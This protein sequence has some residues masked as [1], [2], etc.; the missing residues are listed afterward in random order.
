MLSPRS[1]LYLSNKRS[2]SPQ[3]KSLIEHTLAK[4]PYSSHE[5]CAVY[6]WMHVMP[7][8]RNPWTEL[9][10]KKPGFLV[11]TIL[12][13]VGVLS[14]LINATQKQSDKPRKR[15][16]K[17]THESANL[18]MANPSPSTS[19]CVDNKDTQPHNFVIPLL[20]RKQLI[21]TLRRCWF[22]TSQTNP[23]R[24]L[25]KIKN[26]MDSVFYIILTHEQI[27]GYMIPNG[28]MMFYMSR[29][30]L[31]NNQPDCPPVIGCKIDIMRNNAAMHTISSIDTTLEALFAANPN[32]GNFPVILEWLVYN[33]KAN[34][35]PSALLEHGMCGLASTNATLL[36]VNPPN[37]FTIHSSRPAK[38]KPSKTPL[39][40]M[41]KK[42]RIKIRE[43]PIIYLKFIN[44]HKHRFFNITILIHSITNQSSTLPHQVLTT[45]Q[46]HK[47][48][49]SEKHDLKKG[50]YQCGH[51]YYFFH[52][53]LR[54]FGVVCLDNSVTISLC[55]VI[56]ESWARNK[57]DLPRELEKLIIYMPYTVDSLLMRPVSLPVKFFAIC[58]PGSSRFLAAMQMAMLTTN[59]V[60]T[61]MIYLSKGYIK[62]TY[63]S[64]AITKI[65]ANTFEQSTD[66]ASTVRAFKWLQP[67]A[68]NLKL[69]MRH[70]IA[71]PIPEISLNK[72]AIPDKWT[73]AIIHKKLPAIVPLDYDAIV[74]L[75][76]EHF[77][78][79]PNPMP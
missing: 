23:S 9:D 45:E 66:L 15:G 59:E 47:L 69:T 30:T 56:P 75:V 43:S 58:H 8:T 46:T 25:Y 36:I 7:Y 72:Q 60:T 17:R 79:N 13:C 52:S 39:P 78:I 50:S 1:Q 10:R 33:D 68:I 40:Q 14:Q 21:D 24:T 73:Q 32:A 19:N 70:T 35:T 63:N 77:N 67:H 11:F 4:E 74:S 37:T 65:H 55:H 12:A 6:E 29:H 16:T 26:T 20:D 57:P 53:D 22:D 64:N 42:S 71:S 3:D 2:R 28:F 34:L 51:L 5:P 31:T 41:T 27:E 48:S 76:R 38:P 49:E 44:N 54:F 61:A 18:P 62:I